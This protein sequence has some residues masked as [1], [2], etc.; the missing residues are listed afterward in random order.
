MTPRVSAKPET[1]YLASLSDQLDKFWSIEEVT[2][3]RLSSKDEDECEASFIHNVR[4]S[5][6]GRYIVRLPFRKSGQRL[7]ESRSLAL[8]R[9]SAL[10]RK[11]QTNTRLQTEYTQI[12]DEYLKRNYMSVVEDPVDEGY[13]MPHHAVIKETSNTTKVRV[14]FDASAKTSNGVSLNDALLVGPVIQNTLFSHLL[15]FRVY[16]YV[17]TADI[18]KMYLQIRLHEDD[19][20]YQR[21]L[22]RKDHKIVTLQ[23]NTLTF[24]V[25]SSSFLAVRTVHQLANDEGHTCPRAAEILRKHLYVDDLLS[26]ANSIDKA[27][28][29]RDEVIALL[30]RGGLTIRQWASNEERSISD[31]AAGALHA[32]FRFDKTYSVKTLG[33]TWHAQEDEIRYS[34]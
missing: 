10:E 13:Y 34:I 7:S 12:I 32:S 3:N 26:G 27:R 17:V 20:R 24:G 18:E 8:K 14:V 28:A 21:V 4:R 23:F 29:I 30:A 31:L 11:F 6:C 22:W 1:C 5:E 33:I 19:R 15:R 9:L 16:K 2:V 25:S